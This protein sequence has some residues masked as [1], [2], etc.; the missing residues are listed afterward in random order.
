[1]S[2]IAKNEMERYL[3]EPVDVDIENLLPIK[4]WQEHKTLY[5]TLYRFAL[6]YLCCPPSSV[7]SESLFSTT[8]QIDADRRKRLH[9]DKIEMLAF[10][11]RNYDL[12]HVK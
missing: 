8:G 10:I 12:V 4:W 3:S 7:A 9:T 11:Q 1:M 2:S 6:Q 5:P